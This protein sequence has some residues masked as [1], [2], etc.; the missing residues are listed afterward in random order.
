[1]GKIR[2]L[3]VIISLTDYADLHRTNMFDCCNC[4][5]LIFAD[6]TDF[7]KMEVAEICLLQLNKI[8][9]KQR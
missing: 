5:P 1:M 7:Y 2:V 3:R 4:N 6:Y 9:I 8:L